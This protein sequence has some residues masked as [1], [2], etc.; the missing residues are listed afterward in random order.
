MRGNERGFALILAVF[1]IVVISAVVTGGYF[2]STQQFRVGTAKR[3]TNPGL[4]SAEA[5][6]VAGLSAWDPARAVQLAPGATLELAASELSSGDA[7]RVWLTRLDADELDPVSYYM[8][9]SLG[10]ARGAYGGR[11]EVALLIR[12]QRPD[13]LCCGAAL[14]TRGSVELGEGALIDGWDT[15]PDSWGPACAVLSPEMGVGLR[16]DPGDGPGVVGVGELR[17]EPPLVEESLAEADLFDY[18]DLDFSDLVR[19]ADLSFSGPLTLTSLEP[20]LTA[21]GSCAVGAEDNWG[22]PGA[23]GHPCFDYYPVVHVAGD[24]ELRGRLRGQG[25]LLVEGDLTLVDGAE[26]YGTIIVRGSL[27]MTGT[28]TRLQGG[29]R[30]FNETL[31]PL[32]ILDGAVVARSRCAILRAAELSVLNWPAPLAQRAWLELLN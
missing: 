2:L 29:A 31:D 20:R 1:A 5:G 28:G 21:A 8:V 9:R 22:A 15:F 10:R 26:F 7:Y 13:S 24:L 32:R 12:T 27:A 30:V 16:I 23:P 17:G 19:L 25:V 14:E 4:Y 6:L 3:Q 18:G 11:R